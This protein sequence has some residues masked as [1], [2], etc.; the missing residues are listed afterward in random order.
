MAVLPWEATK[1]AVATVVSSRRIRMFPGT[2]LWESCKESSSATFKLRDQKELAKL[3]NDI[4]QII[5]ILNNFPIGCVE[6]SKELAKLST[7]I[8]QIIWILKIMHSTQI[9]QILKIMRSMQIIQILKIMRL[10]QIIRILKIMRSMQIIRI[11]KIMRSMQ[12]I[13]I[14]KIMH[15]M[16]IIRILEIMRLTQIIQILNNFPMDSQLTKLQKRG[17]NKDALRDQ[18]ELAMEV[19]SKKLCRCV[20]LVTFVD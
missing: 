2:P 16:Q 18:K 13:W 6:R 10:T 19:T 12:I 9:I 3:S 20:W 17:T 5:R 15:S 14:L 8:P 1:A 11:L 7:D 4:P